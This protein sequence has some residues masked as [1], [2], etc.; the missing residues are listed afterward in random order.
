[1]SQKSLEKVS[2]D[3]VRRD[4]KFFA[5]VGFNNSTHSLGPTNSRDEIYSLIYGFI[6]DLR[7]IAELELKRKQSANN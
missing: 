4:E 7:L 2:V 5:D 1:M 3:V 6:A